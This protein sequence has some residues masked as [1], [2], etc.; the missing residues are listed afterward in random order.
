M[1]TPVPVRWAGLEQAL[2]QVN[3]WGRSMWEA[4]DFWESCLRAARNQAALPP[5]HAR[6]PNHG[7]L[8]MEWEGMSQCVAHPWQ[9]QWHMA[10]AERSSPS[11]AS[12]SAWPKSMSVVGWEGWSTAPGTHGKLGA[13]LKLEAR[14]RQCMQCQGACGFVSF[15]LLN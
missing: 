1:V 13:K 7:G 8:E 2:T 15:E 4:T 10:A 3:R 9:V 12:P 14:N 5:G 11:Q 6:S